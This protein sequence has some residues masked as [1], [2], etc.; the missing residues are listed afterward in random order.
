MRE[1]NHHPH[2]LS[3]KTKKLIFGLII[4]LLLTVFGGYELV[5]VPMD[6]TAPAEEDSLRV[7]FLDVGQGDSTL[8]CMPNGD[9]ALVDAGEND[10]G[11]AVTQKLRSYGVNRL[12]FA[13]GTHP[14]SDHIGGLDVVLS[15]IDADVIYMP[16]FGAN[17]QSYDD[18]LDVI[19]AGNISA[20]IPEIG[21]VIYNEDGVRVKVLYNGDGAEDANNASIVLRVTYGEDALLLTGDAETPVENQLLQ[22]GEDLTANLYKFGHHGSST[23]NSE[24]FLEAVAPEFGVVSCGK[25]NDYGHP[26]R[27]IRQ[28]VKKYGIAL[29]RTDE[30]GDILFASEGTG[31]E[32]R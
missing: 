25:D 8:L 4:I 13:V 32:T 20:E 3:P 11:E 18:L 9:F 10:Y 7:V 21:D 19:E 14:H 23:S 24:A 29:Y 2:R 1:S 17:T 6:E 22:A 30:M 5:L 12:S 27:E 16:D 15:E 31:W 28:R 26:H